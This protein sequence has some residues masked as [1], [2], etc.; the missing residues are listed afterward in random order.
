MFKKSMPMCALLLLLASCATPSATTVSKDPTCASKKE[1]WVVGEI[2]AIEIACKRVFPDTV[3]SIDQ[4]LKSFRE[5]HASCFAQY[6]RPG[7]ERDLTNGA[8]AL[9]ESYVSRTSC[10]SDLDKVLKGGISLLEQ[11]D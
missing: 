6:D 10:V 2:L 5:A 7:R 11:P 1:H 4:K 8:A 9:N 3:L